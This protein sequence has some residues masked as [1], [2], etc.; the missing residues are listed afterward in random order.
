MCISTKNL[1]GIENND[2][3]RVLIL[4]IASDHT[5]LYIKLQS[6]WRSYMHSDPSR[7]SAYFIK[8]DPNLSANYYI[9]KD[10]IWSKTAECIIPGILNKTILSIEALLSQIDRFDYI[11]RT[12]L[13]SFYVFPK[14]LQ[15]LNSLPTKKCYSAHIG[16]NFRLNQHF[17]TGSGFILSTDVAKMLVHKKKRLFNNEFS[18][19]DLVI[20]R[21]L[22]Q[23]KIKLIPAPRFDFYSM[24]DWLAS[25]NSLLDKHFHF[26]IKNS[27]NA[28]RLE[29]DLY[30]Y[31]QLIDKYYP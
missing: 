19:D 14:L 12:N 29:Q 25:K 8:A 1:Y 24:N 21:F 3:P 16:Y 31:S 7:I 30:I 5:P 10:V 22:K 6:L 27:N 11:L 15:F 2:H 13:S 17:G 20:A 4:I 9:H 18:N 23:H 28:F 26:R